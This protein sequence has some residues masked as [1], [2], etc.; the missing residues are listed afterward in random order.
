MLRNDLSTQHAKYCR[1][2]CPHVFGTVQN[3]RNLPSTLLKTNTIQN[4]QV[5]K[6]DDPTFSWTDKE[7]ELLLESAKIFRVNMKAEGVNWENLRTKYHKI[8]EIVQENYPK[9]GDIE[10]FPYGECI[11]K[12]HKARITSKIKKN[13]F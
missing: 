10:E 6:K 12:L 11:Q 3:L 4:S 9:T 5:N 13:L 1:T 8:M 2:N 7:V